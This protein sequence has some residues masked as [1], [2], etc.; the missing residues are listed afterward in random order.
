MS[1]N[2][3]EVVQD[4]LAN[5]TNSEMVNK[6][7]AADATYISLNFENP[8]LKQIMPWAGTG[9]GPEAF[10]STF[11]RVGQYWDNLDFE[12]TDIFG[13]D[14]RVAVFGKFTYKSKVVG[15]TLTSPF[16]ILAK[17]KERQITYFQFM[18]D[19]FGTA[20][21]FKVKGSWTFHS[22]PKGKPFDI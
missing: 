12:V 2:P 7:V 19:T 17:V 1:R 4:F 21:T 10:L 3:I 13:S 9:K 8:A 14:E 15:K 22:D 18:E 11:V 16:S 6:L 20:S 5:T